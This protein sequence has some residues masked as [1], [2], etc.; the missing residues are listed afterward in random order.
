MKCIACLLGGVCLLAPLGAATAASPSDALASQIAEHVAEHVNTG[1]TTGPLPDVS[2]F[3]GLVSTS[4]WSEIWP[5]AA[6][7]DVSVS[8]TS[9]IWNNAIQTTL[10]KYG[11]V[12]LPKKDSPYYI[13]NPIILKSGQ[14]L[15]A[16]P[17]AEIRLAPNA[18][19][20]MVR[21][22][23]MI[24]GQNG[25]LPAQKTDSNIIVEGGIWTTLATSSTQFNGN[26]GGNS[27]RSNTIPGC[28]GVVA[29]NNV[30]GLVARNLTVRQSAAHGLQISDC[31]NFL[32]DGVTFDE[33][34][35]DGVHINGSANYAVIRNVAGDTYDDVVALNAWDWQNSAPAFGQID[36]V[37]VDNVQGNPAGTG[38]DAIRL[39]PGHKNFSG[40]TT[41]ECSI[42]DCVLRNLSDIRTIKMY[43]QPNL[44]LG[45]DVDHSDPIGNIRNVAFSNLVYTKPGTIQVDA[46]VGSLSIDNVQL[47]YDINAPEHATSRLVSVG[48]MSMTYKFDPNNSA[49]WVEVFSP[50]KDITVQGFHMTNVSAMIDN[51]KQS[52]S[53]PEA[54]LI[55][56]ASQKLNP[57]YPN[58]TPRGGTGKVKLINCLVSASL[59]N[60]SFE[61]GS[62]NSGPPDDWSFG[63]TYRACQENAALGGLATSA[64]DAKVM[65]LNIGNNASVYAYQDLPTEYVQG[66]AYELTISLGMRNDIIGNR[67]YADSEDW[68]LS[69]NYADTGE[70]IARL[71]GTI[72]NNSEHAGSLTD[73]TLFYTTNSE[74][75]GHGIQIRILGSTEGKTGP[76][77]SYLGLLSIDNVRIDAYVVPEQ[78]TVSM[79][80][81]AIVVGTVMGIR[82]KVPQRTLVVY[83]EAWD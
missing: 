16:A 1:P 32:V 72:L 44:E 83:N 75:V 28:H 74:D 37:L 3:G 64:T 54:R 10:N 40:G 34:R 78:S 63:G 18:S 7:A 4:T 12:Y 33:H 17:D 82:K 23:N 80:A 41:L 62:G 56:V 45:R 38:S 39:L 21:N 48:P 57:T 35:R 25:A 77:T 52:V 76:G 22:Q 68:V 30:D 81:L 26:G 2:E 11:A 58:T 9:G 46:N 70:E 73:Q 27:D 5:N 19:T 43:D 24:S 61:S 66:N 69:L 29:M 55:S 53:R 50:D 51:V 13:D 65:Q 6:G 71:A 60:A 31:S 49:T 15:T 47:K 36:H 42:S 14:R 8:V 20:C 59:L 79:L 67:A